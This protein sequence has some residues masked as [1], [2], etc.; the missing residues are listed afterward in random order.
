[1]RKGFWS[2]NSYRILKELRNFK[3]YKRSSLKNFSGDLKKV[4]RTRV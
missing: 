3:N 2:R 4:L 1:M